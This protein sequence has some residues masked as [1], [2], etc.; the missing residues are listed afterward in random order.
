[1]ATSHRCLFVFPEFTSAS[2]W[3][4]RATCELMGARYPA[5]P[6][7]MITVA[8][9]LPESWECRLVDCNVEELHE[10]DI[11]WADITIFVRSA[12]ASARVITSMP[13]ASPPS[14]S[15]TTTTPW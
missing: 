1:M 6:L 7:G 15:G 8:A 2:F 9:M 11:E 12:N 3:N 14:R 5:A 10:R 13:L 4:Y